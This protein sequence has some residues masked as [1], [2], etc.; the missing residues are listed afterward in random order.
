MSRSGSR[1]VWLSL[2]AARGWPVALGCGGSDEHG[3]RRW[4]R[5][6]CQDRPAAARKRDAALR[7][8]GPAYFEERV[9]EKCPDCEVLY[10]NA[11]GD[12]SKQQS[13]AE[14]ALTQGAEVLV[15]DP[16]DAKSAA[17]IVEKA[18]AQDVPVLSYDRLIENAEVDSYVSFDNVQVGELQA[19][20]LAEKTERRR[21]RRAA[22]SS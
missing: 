20:T 1:G 19:E 12:A 7:V 5:R 13:Q 9:E 16:M 22:R 11:D 18:N 17:A 10:S 4:R 6:R 8:G 15:L 2:R 14:A 3:R 21:Q